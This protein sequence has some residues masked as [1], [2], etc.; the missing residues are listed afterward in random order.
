MST[1]NI[2]F[3]IGIQLKS[4]RDFLLIFLLNLTRNVGVFID[5]FLRGGLRPGG[6][7]VRGL[8]LPLGVGVDLVAAAVQEDSAAD[9]T[10]LKETFLVSFRFQ[11]RNRVSL[12]PI[13]NV[14]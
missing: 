1:Y 12:T 6:G 2:A 5:H 8:V 7:H 3:N 4:K 10:D 13:V 11:E 9:L 14:I